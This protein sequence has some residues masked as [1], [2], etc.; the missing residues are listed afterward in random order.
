VQ[1]GA[2]IRAVAGASNGL[3]SPLSL[4]TSLR[5]VDVMLNAGATFTQQLLRDENAVLFV[6][7]GAIEVDGAIVREG[8]VGVSATGHE[9]LVVSAAASPA[10]FTLFGGMPLHQ[11][12]TQRGPFVASDERELASFMNA[13]AAGRMGQLTPFAQKP[14]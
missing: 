7:G 12:R 4:Q 11:P 5:I 14:F 10:R 2:R 1:D 8:Q 3:A 13:F 9:M 6:H